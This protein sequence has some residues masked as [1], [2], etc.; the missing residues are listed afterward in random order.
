MR[1]MFRVV[2]LL[3]AAAAGVHGQ[4]VSPLTAPD[5]IFHNGKM[6]PVDRPFPIDLGTLQTSKLR[7]IR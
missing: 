1:F 3:L 7:L 4:Q 6:I 5:T 2:V